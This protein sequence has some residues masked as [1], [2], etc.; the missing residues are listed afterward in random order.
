MGNQKSNQYV[1]IIPT[2]PPRPFSR[3]DGKTLVEIV[4]EGGP[5]VGFG[6]AGR[7]LALW[8]ELGS[9]AVFCV[10]EETVARFLW[11]HGAPVV[12]G[13]SAPIVVL[14]RAGPVAVEEV[15]SLQGEGRRVVL[16]DDLGPAR[17]AADIVI[18]P[19]T[20]ATWPPAAGLCLGG[21]EHVLLR[22]E[23][24][25]ARS[26]R[27]VSGG[28]LVAM[29][30]SDPADLTRPLAQALDGVGLDVTVVL[31]PGYRG[32]FLTGRSARV[33]QADFAATLA[34]SELLVTGYGHSLLEAAHLGVPA[35]A[36][37]NRL[38]HLPHARAFCEE[39][40]ARMLDMTRRPHPPELAE[41]VTE[42][43]GDRRSRTAMGE[44]GEEL[45]DGLGA[46]R[47]AEAIVGLHERSV[48]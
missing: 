39:G 1:C 24:R 33:A 7:C 44:R 21:F 36:V 32:S 42:L 25:E 40:T 27:T 29:G 37:V 41:L 2:S 43:F 5:R 13:G 22:R 11:A 47:I 12:P 30:G 15:R 45:V 31:G 48:G 9:R 46:E 26:T 19:P 17:M 14:D 3:A 6:H 18:D 20:A 16:V 34:C 28:V 35:V 4:L 23:V 38:E 10:Q 8:E